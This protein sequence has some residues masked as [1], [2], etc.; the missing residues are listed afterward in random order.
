MRRVGALILSGFAGLALQA[1]TV[2]D[3]PA[4]FR[5]S[6][7]KPMSDLRAYLGGQD[8]VYAY[9][10]GYD[11][12]GPDAWAG[13]GIYVTYLVAN[14]S[15]IST[16]QGLTQSVYG[17]RVGGDVRFHTPIKGLTPF[18]G[19]SVTA[20]DGKVNRGGVVPN[21]DTP[22][23]PYV[24][25]AAPYPEGKGK[26]GGR[27]GVEYRINKEWGVALDYSFSEWRSDFQLGG[28][29]PV[30]GQRV[31]NGLNPVNPSWIALSAQY[32]FSIW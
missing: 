26:F 13:L 2:A 20:Y 24:V 27:V 19:F 7:V 4:Y 6:A 28:Y 23:Q 8:L 9:E 25:P 18:I 5:A 11:F 16:Y 29:T 12:H 17:W 21:Y 14:G 22:S 3:F 30:T 10:L 32:R 1:Q 15:P 31:V